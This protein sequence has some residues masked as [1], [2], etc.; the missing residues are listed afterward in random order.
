MKRTQITH[1]NNGLRIIS[2]A[3]PQ[4]E[5]VAIGLWIRAGLESEPESL[6]GISHYLEHMLFKGTARRSARQIS[7]E[8]DN[9][10]GHLNGYTDR[11]YTSLYVHLAG[12]YLPRAVDLL[13]DM[14][15]HST[16][17]AEEVEKER[18]V[19]LQ[20]DLRIED[21]PEDQVHDLAVQT[22]WFDHPLGRI[23]QGTAKSIRAIQTQDLLDYYQ[24]CY[25]PERILVSAAG[26]LKHE[27][28]VELVEQAAGH[29]TPGRPEVSPPP[30][31][32]H[33][34]RQ[35]VNRA[36]EQVQLCLA[37]PGCSQTD[38]RRYA[39]ALYDLILGASSSSRLFQEIRE[40]R[41]LAYA[42]ASYPL[43]CRK[44]GLLL[45]H[46]GAGSKSVAQV[47]E[48]IRQELDELKS[49][50]ITE[51]ELR[52]TKEH[53][54]GQIALAR[55]S[56]AYRTQRLA[57]SLLY[58]GRVIPYRELLNHFDKVSAIDI[59]EVAESVCS[60]EPTIITLG[61]A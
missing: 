56:T 8:I 22:A 18:E 4:V 48:L 24:A 51:E 26:A 31:V 23:L 19:I 59:H 42:I 7:A 46:A 34:T 37:L 13:F 36:V 45:I 60:L 9:V 20:E 17:A 58:E 35:A 38:K 52:W 47:L 16:V 29:L 12:E 39:F 32:F 3:L 14:A 25:R 49:K 10:G 44:A 43:A 21:N 33:S 50:G 5:S 1:L 61:P 54:K 41:G 28:L 53:V 57:H 40:S 6:V 2:E 30:P 15:L 11:E 27:Q 55:E